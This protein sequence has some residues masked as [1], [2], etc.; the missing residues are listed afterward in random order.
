MQALGFG[1]CQGVWTLHRDTDNDHVHLVVNRVN[2]T[3]LPAVSVPWRDY[4]LLDRCMR[5]LE[6]ELGFARAQGPYVT[7]DTVERPKIVR[8]SRAER[9]TPG[10][11]RN[12]DCPRLSPSA[13]RA[14][15]NLTAS[16]FQKWL[17]GAPSAA[18]HRVI[19]ARGAIWQHAHD[20][21]AEFGCVIKPKGSGM[22]VTT[23]LSDGRVLA[24]KASLLGRWA[25]K[26]SLERALGAYTEPAAGSPQRTDPR[27]T[28]EQSVERER[29]A[30]ILPRR[31]RNEISVGRCA[32]RP[33]SHRD[34]R[35]ALALWALSAAAQAALRGIRYRERRKGRQQEEI[36][37][38]GIAP[39]RPFTVSGLR[40][41]VDA[42]RHVIIY[43][44]ADG[45]EVFRDVGPRIVVRDK[46]DESL[47]AALRAAAQ[48]YVGRIQLTGSESFRERAAA[49]A[50]RLGI[51]VE[52]AEHSI[53]RVA[54]A[55]G[56]RSEDV[57]RRAFVRQ[58]G[59]TPRA[60]QRR[61]ICPLL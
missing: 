57:F 59:V 1:E 14:E 7:V 27:R 52:N 44:R 41:E 15:H 10:L 33:L 60:Y 58:F 9:A 47:E 29:H 28:Y 56:Y 42:A 34:G 50:T 26:A 20:A 8:M 2:P 43:R 23:T 19:T 24:A 49:M 40:A 6:L 31:P 16:S 51:V 22:V 30:E 12:L 3:K 21:L 13:Q 32:R 11:L 48:K 38:E 17:T 5:E 53:D 39:Q 18:L 25:S 35:V 45:S 46:G 61:A 54:E 4:F 36:A 37:G 55:T